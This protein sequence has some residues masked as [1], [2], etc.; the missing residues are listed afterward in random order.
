M[1]LPPLRR[2]LARAALLVVACFV[3][4]PAAP[5]QSFDFTMNEG[6]LRRLIKENA[7]QTTLT[8]RMDDNGPLHRIGSDCE[9]HI[10]GQV[11]NASPGNPPA[12]VVE[13]PN[14]CKFAPDG[15]QG[16]SF[17]ALSDRWRDLVRGSV[18]DR[19]C[20]VR[21]FLRIFT[22]HASGGGA[23]GSNPDHAYELHPA[24]GM[25]C[26]GQTFNF[27]SMLRAFPGMRHIQPSTAAGCINDRELYA[28]W[29]NNR[30]E[31]QDG[32]GTCGNFAIVEVRDIDMDWSFAMAGGHYTFATVTANGQTQ[33][34]VGV[35]TLSGSEADGWLAGVIQQGGVGNTRKVLHGMFTYDPQSIIMALTDEQGNL[36]RPNL[37]KRVDFPLALVIFGETATVPWEQ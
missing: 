28:R 36:V 29:R 14:W 26:G 35:Y 33:S 18:I 37:W 4:A 11:Q 17:A 3:S 2:A 21:G 19:T 5:A 20:E 12:I 8:V 32:G 22:E 25:A 7:V 16:L 15:Q 13:F 10:A 34:T 24:L 30:Y 31:F 6:F 1:T 23:G 9:M 27:D